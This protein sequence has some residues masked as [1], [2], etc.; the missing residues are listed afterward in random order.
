[1]KVKYS[2]EIK[3]VMEYCVREVL[4]LFEENLI[5]THMNVSTD[6]HERWVLNGLYVSYNSDYWENPR[7]YLEIYN[8]HSQGLQE[9]DVISE[10]YI[11]NRLVS[12]SGEPVYEL[13]CL[14]IKHP[15]QYCYSLMEEFFI[16]GGQS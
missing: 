14:P 5:V 2:G 7:F 13:V 16:N 10:I 8:R 9:G 4:D 11:E 15:V 6:E 1:M 12:E 3:E